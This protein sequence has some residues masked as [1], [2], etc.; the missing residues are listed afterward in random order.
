MGGDVAGINLL[1]IL[2][3]SWC[4]LQ[5]SG[6]TTF[7]KTGQL[8]LNK[9]KTAFSG[10]WYLPSCSNSTII[11]CWRFYWVEVYS[12]PENKN[13]EIA[14]NAIKYAKEKGFDTVIVDTAGRLAVDT[15]M[16]D[17]ISRVQKQSSHMKLCL[18]LMQWQVKM[19]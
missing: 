17:E 7:P 16:M 1:E 8:S 3:L 4:G 18:L 13:P 14:Q 10:L 5:G 11:R 12:E 19:Q 2:Q 6:K 15:E 9:K